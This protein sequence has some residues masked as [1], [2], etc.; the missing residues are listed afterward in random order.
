MI[1]EDDIGCDNCGEEDKDYL[2]KYDEDF[3]LCD[4]CAKE[5]DY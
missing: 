3:W 5:A 4:I 2:T 1:V